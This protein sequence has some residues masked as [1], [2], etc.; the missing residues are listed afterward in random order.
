MRRPRPSAGRFRPAGCDHRRGARRPRQANA[1][2]T[3][4]QAVLARNGVQLRGRDVI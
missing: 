1:R 4:P 2:G 3:A